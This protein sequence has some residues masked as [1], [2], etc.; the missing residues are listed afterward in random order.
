MELSLI[1]IDRTQFFIHIILRPDVLNCIVPHC[2]VSGVN[3][4]LLKIEWM[5]S[6]II[7]QPNIITSRVRFP[8]TNPSR[9]P[10]NVRGLP[11]ALRNVYMSRT[12]QSRM[13]H[14]CMRIISTHNIRMW[15]AHARE[16]GHCC[17]RQHNPVRNWTTLM[18]PTSN[19][20]VWHAVIR[21]MYN[22]HEYRCWM[23]CSHITHDIIACALIEPSRVSSKPTRACV[24]PPHARTSYRP[25][26]T[27]QLRIPYAFHP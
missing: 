8:R 9:W 18:I 16:C 10:H 12:H 21:M 13:Q 22:V 3:V 17:T 4:S 2:R 11:T 15:R 25:L 7:F 24:L 23:R 20:P 6:L 1:F 19:Q 14:T 5:L 26:C 27:V